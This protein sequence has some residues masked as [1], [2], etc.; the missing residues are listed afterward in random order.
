MN[1]KKNELLKV[2]IPKLQ[3]PDYTAFIKSA[4]ENY[5][6]GVNNSV[7]SISG[8]SSKISVAIQSNIDYVLHIQKVLRETFN[9]NLEEI[10]RNCNNAT[11]D[12]FLSNLKILG[13]Y[14]WCLFNIDNLQ[15]CKL[16]TELLINDIVNQINNSLLKV[17]DIDEYIG[18]L[19]T[20]GLLKTIK[21]LTLDN[22]DIEDKVKLERAFLQY[23]AG[24]YLETVYLLFSLIDAQS[25]KQEIYDYNINNY[26]KNFCKNN[27]FN[28]IQ[29]WKSF[30]RTF[31]HNFSRYFNGASL[32]KNSK[33]SISL[34][35]DMVKDIKSNF[36]YNIEVVC[37]IIHL[38]Y[39]L[40]KTFEDIS[41]ANYKTQKPLVINRH[42]VMHGMYSVNDIDKYDCIKL[43]LLLYQLSLLYKKVRNKEI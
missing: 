20:K 23:N 7:A 30:Y 21:E 13:E 36:T 17:E 8:A 3:V 5:T 27:Q 31:E 4:I 32:S 12:K 42:W 19:F 2:D 18:K 14:G 25:I 43:M 11:L 26:N 6:R 15:D 29:G 38:S 41:W 39:S 1:N 34:L 10:F 35:D 37:P 28:P 40:N 24:A 9:F 22:L 33:D 16:N